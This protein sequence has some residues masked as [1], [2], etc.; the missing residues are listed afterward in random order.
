MSQGDPQGRPGRRRVESRQELLARVVREQEALHPTPVYSMRAK[1]RLRIYLVLIWPLSFAIA[2]L[3]GWL[4][5]WSPL[6]W[7]GF[8][9]G[10]VLAFAYIGYVLITERDDGRIHRST[11]ALLDEGRAGT[12]PAD[13]SD[14]REGGEG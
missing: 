1:R 13:P 10:L 2:G 11:R 6:E 7:M 5:G 14:A 8:A 4:L 12:P 3:T 9:V